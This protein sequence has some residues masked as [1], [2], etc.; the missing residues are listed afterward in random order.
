[1][2]HEK[3]DLRIFVVIIPKEGLAG[4]VLSI[5]LFHKRRLSVLEKFPSQHPLSIGCSMDV[6]LL[7]SMI[8]RIYVWMSSFF[9][10]LCANILIF[11][12]QL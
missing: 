10:I 4:R 5:L 8:I 7:C 11:H 3:T 2:Q 9:N 6:R 12:G 1:M